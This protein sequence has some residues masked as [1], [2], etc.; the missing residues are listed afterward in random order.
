MFDFIRRHTR[1]TLGF[2][3]LLIIPSF[4]FFG[5]EG[6]SRFNDESATA[7]ASVAGR[8]IARAEWDAAHQRNVQRV[9][10]DQPEIELAMLSTSEMRM[11]TLEGLLR[12]R[13]LMAAAFDQ[14]LFPADARLQRL[15]VS[16][17]QFAGMRNP[18]GSVNR[19]ILAAQGMSSDLFAQQLRQEFAMKQVLGGL[20]GSV[21]APPTVA[22]AALDPLLQR[23]AFELQWF[24]PA[25]YR[26]RVQPVD[27]DLQAFYEA[28]RAQFQAPEQASIEYVV[29][30]LETLARGLTLEEAELQRFYEDNAARYTA[31]EERRARHILILSDKDQPAAERAKARARATELLAEARRNPAGF[32]ELARKHSQDPGSAAQG[33]DLDFFPRGAMVKPFE[34][35][36]FALSKGAISEVVETDFGYHVLQLVDQRGGQRKAFSEVRSEIEVEL[37]RSQAQRRWAAQAEQFTNLVYEQYDSL[38]AA[39]DKL[40][41]P[42]QTAVVQ[43]EPAPGAAGPLDSRKFIDALFGSE[44]L[45]NKRNTDAIEI[46]S[47]QLV[48]GRV[49]QHSPAR[50]R[51]LDE[52]RDL[53]RERFIAQRAAEMAR[54]EGQTRLAALQAAGATE[55]LPQQL[56][57]SRVQ[58]QGLPPQLVDAVLTADAT[59]LPQLKAVDLQ[60]QGYAVVRVTQVLPRDPAIGSE[61]TLR[62]QY[63]QTWAAAEAEAYLKALRQRYKAQI[64]PAAGATASAGS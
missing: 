7:V 61:S 11:Q 32:A 26:A 8:D 39:A 46:A 62:D 13:V 1:L 25:V 18:D 51:P 38:K 6:Y 22:A 37:R 42:I 3:L 36:A 16:D 17:P 50:D 33:G 29:L 40:Q 47:N 9:L 60:E 43:R 27:A 52:V 12:E 24:D 4:V 45:S 34:D 53:V 56:T 30:D 31:P 49:L 59:R 14:Q 63:A 48:A 57:L 15:F 21:T 41:L 23:R 35:V 44:S 20:T 54:A 2:L 5:I 58:T 19:D 10:R 55:A 64:R 28:Q